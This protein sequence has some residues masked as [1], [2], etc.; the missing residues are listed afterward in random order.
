MFASVRSRHT[1]VA[2]LGVIAA[3]ASIVPALAQSPEVSINQG[4]LIGSQD[5]NVSSFL[6]IP[7]A[8]PPIDQLR[9]QPPAQAPSWSKLRD[10]IAFGLS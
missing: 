10:D 5:G 6:G 1:A 9:W 7:Y 3:A 2:L 8:A 4:I